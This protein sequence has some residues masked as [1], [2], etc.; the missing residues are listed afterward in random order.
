MTSLI[1]ELEYSIKQVDHPFDK[2][3]YGYVSVFLSAY[4]H[5]N[6]AYSQAAQTIKRPFL[7]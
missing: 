3:I 4:Y 6:K 2:V 1:S 7:S 5:K